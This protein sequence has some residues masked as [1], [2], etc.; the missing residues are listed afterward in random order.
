MA[1][2]ALMLVD[3]AG[4]GAVSAGWYGAAACILV[5]VVL[6]ASGLGARRD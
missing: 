6:C 1:F 4:W 5:G 3:T 2:G